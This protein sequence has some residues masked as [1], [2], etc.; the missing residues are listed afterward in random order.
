MVSC[1]WGSWILQTAA[2]AGAA[3]GVEVGTILQTAAVAGAAD[4]VEVGTTMSP[5]L[6]SSGGDD[7]VPA[8][9]GHPAPVARRPFVFVLSLLA[10]RRR[11]HDS[12]WLPPLALEL[13]DN[14]LCSPL[15]LGKEAQ[16]SHMFS[17]P[18]PP[19]TS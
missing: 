7:D 2:V 18:S 8:S 17:P 9:G 4:G 6:G 19:S 13:H 15:I 5:R 3:D 12:S 16:L 1:V 14:P 10:P 11:V